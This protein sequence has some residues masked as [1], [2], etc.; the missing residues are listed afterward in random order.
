MQDHLIRLRIGFDVWHSDFAIMGT[1]PSEPSP[2]T[3]PE[4]MQDADALIHGF[5][6]LLTEYNKTVRITGDGLREVSKSRKLA[7]SY[8]KYTDTYSFTSSPRA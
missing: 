4:R 5:S 6:V 7:V 8:D 3:P 1:I 2:A